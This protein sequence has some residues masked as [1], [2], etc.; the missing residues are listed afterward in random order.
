MI[1]SVALQRTYLHMHK[2][3]HGPDKADKSS[4]LFEASRGFLC[5]PEDERK[6]S[7]T[8]QF[9][10]VERKAEAFVWFSLMEGLVKGSKRKGSDSDEER[11][12]L[13]RVQ[14]RR[15]EKKE[16]KKSHKID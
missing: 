13:R 10:L 1:D 14:V 5:G 15:E 16:E 6:E 7:E 11:K 3:N 8:A 4:P 2:R 12:E 9:S